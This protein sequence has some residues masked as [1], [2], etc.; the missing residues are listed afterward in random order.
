MITED[1]RFRRELALRLRIYN[2]YKELSG[3]QIK[4]IMNHEEIMRKWLDDDGSIIQYKNSFDMDWVDLIRQDRPHFHAECNYRIKPVVK[5]LTV[6][7][8]QALLGYDIE[9]VGGW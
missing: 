2:N 4:S 9:I 1:E 3:A 8:I 6:N 5:K 7:D